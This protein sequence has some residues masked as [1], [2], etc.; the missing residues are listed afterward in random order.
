MGMGEP[1]DNTE[2]VLRVLD[3]LTSE[4]GMAWS[5]KRITVSTVGINPGLEKFIHNSDCHLALSMHNPFSEERKQ[6]MPIEA[7]YPLRDVLKLIRESDKF[8]G[9]R[10]FSVEYILFDGFNDDARHAREMI[11]ILNGLK[12]RVNLIPFHHVPGIPLK[13]SSR[14]KIELFQKELQQRG[15]T[16]TIRRSRGLDIQAACGL[17]STLEQ[18]QQQKQEKKSAEGL[19]PL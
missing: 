18:V 11:R 2:N 16:T 8:K 6:I 9:Q 14:A 7:Q 19:F 4:K 13:G 5:P 10:R 12:V 1:M 17:L 3:I 15:I